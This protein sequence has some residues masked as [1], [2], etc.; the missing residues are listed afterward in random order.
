MANHILA[1]HL[2]AESVAL[3]VARSTLR[4]FRLQLLAVLER[5]SEAVADIVTS[6]T[7]DRVVASVP[8]DAAVFRILSFPFHDRRRLSHAVGP[9]LEAHVPL[10]LEESVTAW[11]FTRADH[12]GPLLAAMV[13]R[14]LLEDRRQALDSLDI[15][16][17]RFVWEVSALLE[18]YRRAAGP[19]QTFT[20]VDLGSDGATVACFE[21]GRLRGLR[22]GGRH[23]DETTLRNVGWFVRTL[24]PASARALVGGAR[25]DVLLPALREAAPGLAFETLPE[26]CPIE[27][28]E[29][30]APAWRSATTVTGL[31]L[32]AGGAVEA[33]L[34]E[35]PV[36]G[37]VPA[38][39]SLSQDSL[40]RLAPWAGTTA[41]LFLA[42][43]GV[44][45]ARLEGRRARLET[46]AERI[47]RSAMN[48]SSTVGQRLKM[49]TRLAELEQR[50]QSAGGPGASTPLGVL[51]DM[52]SAVPA[53]VDVEFDLYSYDPPNARMRGRAGSFEAVTRVQ[54]SLRASGRFASVEVSGVRAAVSS[55]VEFELA[56]T[57]AGEPA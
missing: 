34:I 10:T 37:R 13:P 53:D 7:W 35:F 32:A 15:R 8:V 43:A 30:A 28:A 14:S 49:E 55:G 11:D 48:D 56:V 38:E 31:A 4:S 29:A 42:A 9:A 19:G 26:R 51:A 27:I 36:D 46:A 2:G 52:S 23:D 20:A 33:P 39:Y 21:N 57:V 17:Q 44:D 16:P 45:H 1:V 41:A 47:Y 12:R 54:E 24:E 6:R 25:A 22:T 40:R 3:A 5:D 50:A 18:I